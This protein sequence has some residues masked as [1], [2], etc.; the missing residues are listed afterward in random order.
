MSYRMS[1]PVSVCLSLLGLVGFTSVSFAEQ[2]WSVN[3]GGMAFYPDEEATAEF[4]LQFYVGEN[5]DAITSTTANRLWLG[6]QKNSTLTVAT[7]HGVASGVP[8]GQISSAKALLIESSSGS[9]LIRQPALQSFVGDEGARFGIV[10]TLGDSSVFLFELHGAKIGFDPVGK[11]LLAESAE[12]SIGSALASALGRENLAGVDV[13]SFK[14]QIHLDW[15]GGE[16]PIEANPLEDSDNAT[17]IDE[18]GVA[19]GNGGTVC[20]LP[21]GPDVIV[22][23]LI[24]T[25]N[26]ASSGGI[27]AFVV[28]TTSCNIGDANLIW[29][30]GS[31]N[32]PVIGQNLFRLRNNRFEHI[33]QGWLKH[34]F[35]ALTQNVCGCGCSGQGGTVLGVG[36]SDPYCCGLNGDQLD[37]GP[38]WQ[39]N[40]W[41]GVFPWPHEADEVSGNSIYKRIQVRISDIDP[42]QNGGG[43]YFV[44]GQ[45]VTPSDSTPGNQNNNASYRPINVTGGGTAWSFNLSGTT[46][47]EQPA[48]RAWQNTDP[49][50]TETDIQIPNEGLLILSGKVTDLGN[51]FWGYEYALQNLNSDRS[52]GSFTVPFQPGTTIQNVGF[53]DVDYHSH[54][55]PPDPASFYDLT[56]WTPTVGS[57][58]ITWATTPYATSQIANALR[59]GTLYNFRFEANRPPVSNTMTLGLFKPGSPS[60]V[61]ATLQG[62]GGSPDCNFNGIADECDVS[63]G[64]SGGPCDVPGCGLSTDCDGNLVL[65][66]CD[67]DCNN[68]TIAD[69]CDILDGTSLDCNGNTVPDECDTFPTAQLTTIRVASGLTSP[70]YVTAPVSDTARLFIVEQTGRIKILD[71][72]TST[73]LGTPY[74]NISALISSGGERGL[75][76]LA[77]DPDYA[78]NGFFYVNY[79]NTAGNTVI[80]RYTVSANPNVAN[81]ASAVILKTITQ[82]FSN[83][84]GGCLQFGPDNMLYVGMGDGGSANDP[85]GNG[86]NTGTLL[87]KMLRLD[88]DNSPTY[89]PA[90]NPFVG[91]GNPLDEIWAIGK[92]NPWRFSFDR[93]TGDMYI[94][95]VGQGAREEIN[96]EPANDPG[97]RNY[98]WR[99]MEGFACTGLSGCTCNSAALTLPILDYTHAAGAC[100]ITGGF[101]YRGCAIPSLHGTY[102]YA[103][104]CADFVRSFEYVGGVV[105]NATDRTV[106][107]IPPVGQGSITSVSSFGEDASGEMYIVTLTGNVYKI[108]PRPTIPVCGN[109]VLES[110][111]TCD[112]SNTVSGD[113]CSATC[114]LENGADDCIDAPLVCP[115]SRMGSTTGSTNDGSA[116]CGDS[117]TSPDIWYRYTPETTGTL[118]IDTCSSANF[119]TVLSVHSGCPGTLGNE[120]GCDDDGCGNSRSSLSVPVTQGSEYFVRVA[121]FQGATGDFTITVDG[122]SCLICP[123]VLFE[124][125]F[126]TNLGWT[127]VNESLTTGQW[128]RAF[129][130]GGGTGDD[131]AD[132]YDGGGQ[133][134]VTDARVGNFDVD[135]GP[136]RLISPTIDMSDGSVT[137]SYA[138]WFARDDLE[139][140]DGVSVEISTDDGN[141]WTLVADHTISFIGW[142]TNSLL[143]DDFV[144]PTATSKL[145]FSCTD[146]PNNSLVEGGVDAVKV[147]ASCFPDCNN[148]GVNDATDISL[149]TSQDCNTNLRPDECDIDLSISEDLEGGPVG[150]IDAGEVIVGSICFGCHD[151]DGSGGPGF[152]GPNIRNH[153]RVQIWTMLLPPTAH[154]GGAFP[155]FT[156]QDFANLEAFLADAGSRG[157]PDRVP[158]ECQAPPDC[159]G[160]LTGDGSELENGTQVDLDHDGV[161]DQCLAPVCS[162]V[163]AA[164]IGSRYVE[165]SAAASTGRMALKIAGNGADPDVACMTRYVQADGTLGSTPVFKTPNAWGTVTVTGF[166]IRPD[167][168]YFA[169]AECLWGLSGDGKML[170]WIRGDLDHSNTVDVDDLIGM[171][172]GFAGNFFFAFEAVSIGPCA[173]DALIDLDDLQELLA[174]FANEVD[175]C[176][177]PCP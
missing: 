69:G 11:L 114:Q 8:L 40:A 65:D 95:D 96:F 45:Y 116:S 138:Y 68:N 122:P 66:E 73:V 52:V 19:G 15:I 70:V 105:T 126:E 41:T 37:L 166:D 53:H 28:G 72:A 5:A 118:S 89:V 156:D 49:T 97:G 165:M 175:L 148:N 58:S 104:Y 88:V 94:G 139:G 103:D 84:N 31:P 161:P 18:G 82:P 93:L 46:A 152:P 123:I 170:T 51:G 109:G 136:T 75:L 83:H 78:T 92:R 137:L 10:D 2:V 90:D 63:C 24:D 4:G 61:A 13:G 142:V 36:C 42:A 129:P 154:P 117:V 174:A 162:D 115:G 143:V 22:G 106:E 39:V 1:R 113:G 76:G 133:A 149:G 145:R 127:V 141:N 101:V 59:W 71:F 130:N 163:T 153:S 150:A 99:C 144:T 151:V 173:P 140:N 100:S 6:V 48:I 14:A 132:D 112:D 29:I 26:Y 85:N 160:D 131:P 60:S 23:D 25:T 158:D 135:G 77:F 38:K 54:N 35:T 128:E 21:V 102:F 50:V 12:L 20:G 47:R 27:E 147:T 107:L 80:A 9:V 62:P 177:D 119:D 67:P 91:G 171:L 164:A 32:H 98:G 64:T 7:I 121:G 159:D 111:E 168:S 125:H 44:E 57:N 16:E 55:V 134:Y 74:L 146:N 81:A 120:V 56:D 110:G 34:A 3:G 108:I 155:G 169:A 79:T 176:P 86:Q 167:T 172:E 124:D 30:A 157:R 87:G 17:G 33:G 43:Q